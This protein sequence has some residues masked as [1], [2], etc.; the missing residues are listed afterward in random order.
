MTD[1]QQRAEAAAAELKTW[2]DALKGLARNARSLKTAIQGYGPDDV[3]LYDV[4]SG[5]CNVLMNQVR[6][7]L[8]DYTEWIDGLLDDTEASPSID[9][10]VKDERAELLEKLKTDNIK[11]FR[12]N[13]KLVKAKAAS[14]MAAAPGPAPPGGGGAL[15][16]FLIF[17]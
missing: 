6:A 17:S 5:N 9:Q 1:E 14:L 15:P 16:F 2:Q 4:T 13:E 8:S 11:L 10:G 7:K 12:E 3:E